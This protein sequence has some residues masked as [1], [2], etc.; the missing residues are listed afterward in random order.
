MEKQKEQ[1]E[2]RGLP[3]LRTLKTD[4][5]EYI[6]EK[7]ISIIDI[8]AAQVKKRIPSGIE[9][10]DEFNKKI[11]K[12]L[13]ISVLGLIFVGAGLGGFLIFTKSQKSKQPISVLTKPIL[14]ADE[15]KEIILDGIWNPAFQ[16]QEN[17]LLYLAVIKQLKETKRMATL[18]EFFGNLKIIPPF[19]LLD[20]F[21]NKFM[22]AIFRSGSDLPVLILNV[23]SYEKAFAAMIKW[24]KEMA[25]DIEKIFTTNGVSAVPDSFS[26]IDKEIQNYDART[27]NDTDGNIILL[28][29]FINR[30]YLVITTGEKA[31]KE[32]IRRFS[33]PY[34]L[35]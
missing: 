24:E 17:K 7:G 15:E 18:S 14:V 16:T 1:K 2:N 28:Y 29:S 33:L 20:V 13:L 11:K 26:F 35:N 22:F 6:K 31:L 27:L 23:K 4:S 9:E 21:E 25:D 5:S 8:V 3:V 32:I 12:I 19:D 30:K 34:Y 10:A